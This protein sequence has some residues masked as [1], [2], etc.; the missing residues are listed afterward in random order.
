MCLRVGE[1]QGD[2]L[3]CPCCLLEEHWRLGHVVDG[4]V[5]N[6]AEG[7]SCGESAGRQQAR[8]PEC[9]ARIGPEL[10]G[11]S[12]SYSLVR[13]VVT[14]AESVRLDGTRIAAIPD[15][16]AHLVESDRV[17]FRVANFKL[18][19]EGHRVLAF[20]LVHA[21]SILIY[22]LRLVS[23]ATFLGT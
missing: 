5:T 10:K 4:T 7:Q 1:Q 18:R 2:G 20:E 19:L 6:P 22:L 23:L 15:D 17:V 13:D 11:W 12:E 21:V 9:P 14:L 16:V 3:L 8:L